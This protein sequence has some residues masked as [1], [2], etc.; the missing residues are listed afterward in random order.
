MQMITTFLNAIPVLMAGVPHHTPPSGSNDKPS[1]A[2]WMTLGCGIASWFFLPLIASVVGILI[3]RGEL[4]AIEQGRSSQAGEL[5]TKIG[6][7]VSI[8]NV[9]ITVV[10]GC[11]SVALIVMIWGGLI[12]GVGGLAIFG[13]L[14]NSLQ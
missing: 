11:L 2:A 8:A 10:S 1:G 12:A 7:Y 14:A 4:K 3:G 13:E 6:Y 5:I 9:V